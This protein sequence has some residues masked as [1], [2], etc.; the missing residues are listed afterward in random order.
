MPDTP[1]GQIVGIRSEKDKNTLKQFTPEQR[2]IRNDWIRR[3][4]NEKLKDTSKL[5]KDFEQL[6]SMFKKMFGNKQS[7]R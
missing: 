1:L 3:Q 7:R 6:S 5:D 4:A 2:K